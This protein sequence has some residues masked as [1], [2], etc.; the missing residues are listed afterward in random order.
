MGKV[1]VG[2][3]TIVITTRKKNLPRNQKKIEANRYTLFFSGP[4]H[5]LLEKIMAMEAVISE[6]NRPENCHGNQQQ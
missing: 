4:F 5:R 3:L 1:A 2:I 6:L